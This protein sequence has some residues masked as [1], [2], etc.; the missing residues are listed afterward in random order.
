MANYNEADT[1]KNLA[2]I[3]NQLETLFKELN[4]IPLDE[5]SERQERVTKKTLEAI[6][7]KTLKYVEKFYDEG[8]EIG[9]GQDKHFLDAAELY[10][11]LL[12]IE[13]ELLSSK[14]NKI[15]PHK[16]GYASKVSN[17]IYDN[18]RSFKKTTGFESSDANILTKIIKTVFKPIGYFVSL[19]EALTP[20]KRRMANTKQ[21]GYLAIGAALSLVGISFIAAAIVLGVTTPLGVITGIGVTVAWGALGLGL[22]ATICVGIGGVILEETKN[23]INKNIFQKSTLKDFE[24]RCIKAENYLDNR[25]AKIKDK[26]KGITIEEKRP[27]MN[28]RNTELQ[29]DDVRTKILNLQARQHQKPSF[30]V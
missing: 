10:K 30:R 23:S 26:V 16:P 5:D 17:A 4:I 18:Y 20:D 9:A 2:E 12:Q 27:E 25:V 28:F 6:I 15:D 14:I 22:A 13:R 3:A 8:I 21:K 1:K 24:Q 29:L 11:Q 19:F 7:E